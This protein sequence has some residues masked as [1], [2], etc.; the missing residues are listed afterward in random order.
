LRRLDDKTRERV[1]VLWLQGHTYRRISQTL[2]GVGLATISRIIDEE[3]RRSPD[4][5]ELRKLRSLLRGLGVGL[6]DAARG[7]RCME[8]LNRLGISLSEIERYVEAIEK[9][10][11][12]HSV[13]APSLV[14]AAGRLVGLESKEGRRYDEV[15]RD[16]EEKVK[17]AGELERRL[18]GI[19]AECSRS[20]EELERA[21][22][23]LREAV[24]SEERLRR[25]GVEKVSELTRFI[26][27]FESLGYDVEKVE[28]LAQLQESRGALERRVSELQAEMETLKS[29]RQA[30][31]SEVERST[32]E[33][34]I[35]AFLRRRVTL[36]ACNACGERA[37]PMPVP[38][39]EEVEE[40]MRE[41]S[42][43][44]VRC[45]HCGE[46]NHLT[47]ERVL[48]EVGWRVLP[49]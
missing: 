37:V 11:A 45:T 12:G 16:Y 46:T 34:H 28:E 44:D 38:C 21:E 24:E 39:S 2:E 48:I 31:A 7:A 49:E 23:R 4:L 41:R 36:I 32:S 42:M 30:L 9:L 22:G 3:R 47:P 26:E 6:P 10:A 20:K 14:D 5:D 8:Q 27:A 18:V 25:L 29:R 15:L 19:K 35:I 43:T 17:M 33:R 13:G 1:F 40:A